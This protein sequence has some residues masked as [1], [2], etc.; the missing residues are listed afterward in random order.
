MSAPNTDKPLSASDGERRPE[1]GQPKTE[2]RQLL[3]PLFSTLR[4]LK[5]VL[6]RPS[7]LWLG[8]ASALCLMGVIVLLRGCEGRA[9][10]R[11]T[12]QMGIESRFWVRVL[13]LDNVTECTI[14]VSSAFRLA[15]AESAPG[16]QADEPAM[17]PLPEPAKIGLADGR[18]VLGATP[19]AGKEVMLCPEPPYI[20]G[21]NSHRYRG[22]LKLVVDR[23]GRSFDAVNLVPLEPYLAGVVGEEM[24][25]YWE[26][27]ALKAQAIAARTYCLFVKNR[28]GTSRSYDVRRT[29]SSQVY[30]GIG[31]ES[32]QIWDAVNS[33]CGQVLIAPELMAKNGEIAD[34]GLRIAD[35]TRGANPQSAIINPQSCGLFPA[36]YGSSCGGHTTSSE[37][38]FG[39][40]FGPLKGV[41]CPY[42]KDVAK[43]ELFHWPAAAFDRA[44]VTKRLIE[45]YPNLESLGEITDLTAIEES[46][47]GSY[48]R[49][50]RIRLTGATGKTDT[51]RAEDLRLALDPSGRKIRSAMCLIVL[52]G[53]GWAFV[54]GRGWGHGVG[55]CQCGAEGMARLGS[56][57]QS[58]L[59]HYYPGAEIVNVY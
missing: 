35:S 4:S 51:L 48:S 32:V 5:P 58:I 19:L 31:A 50:R 41:L 27:Q 26:P 20:F 34:F 52:S 10:I 3:R 28:F 21:L 11:P 14:E 13:L 25:G 2:D 7:V 59:R 24:P 18:L 54:S 44:T 23:D 42:C 12:P 46:C 30:G 55:M 45:R 40:S 1:D 22:R 39:D 6:R 29:Q 56:D 15:S 9:P 43:W 8:A 49:L 37:E 17:E 33:T 36:Y 38:V 47:Y 16:A 57:A 53:D